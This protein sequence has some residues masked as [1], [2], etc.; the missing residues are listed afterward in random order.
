MHSSAVA[1]LVAVCSTRQQ[2]PFGL[3]AAGG[4]GAL[5]ALIARCTRPRVTT[6]VSLLNN[7]ILEAVPA[8]RNACVGLLLR[9]SNRIEIAL[10]HKMLA[11]QDLSNSTCCSSNFG[12]ATFRIGVETGRDPATFSQPMSFVRRCSNAAA[13]C[14]AVPVLISIIALFHPPPSLSP[15]D[16]ST[17]LPFPFSSPLSTPFFFAF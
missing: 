9:A 7:T 11:S 15:L 14:N 4:V 2:L 13:C 17:L 5:A 1:A 3:N 16:P 8:V 6:R 10:Q 12:P